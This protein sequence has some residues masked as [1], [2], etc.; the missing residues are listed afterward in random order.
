MNM[1]KGGRNLARKVSTK[2][3]APLPRRNVKR[4]GANK[5]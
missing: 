5:I 1:R 4:P 2:R 3:E